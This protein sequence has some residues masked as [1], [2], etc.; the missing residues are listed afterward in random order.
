MITAIVRYK[1]PST[2]GRN[3]CLAA[4]AKGALR[5]ERFEAD[6]PNVHVYR[7]VVAIARGRARVRAGGRSRTPHDGGAGRPGEGGANA[8]SFVGPRRMAAVIGPA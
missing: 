4:I 3:E 8:G 2:I 6:T 7:D 5:I 1:L